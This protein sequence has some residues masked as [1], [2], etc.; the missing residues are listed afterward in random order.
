MREEIW[1]EKIFK[2]D[3]GYFL[4]ITK[5]PRCNWQNTD[6]RNKRSQQQIAAFSN[7]SHNDLRQSAYFLAWKRDAE[8]QKNIFAG[9]YTWGEFYI[10]WRN[11]Q[12]GALRNQKSTQPNF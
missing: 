4:R 12:K 11:L 2:D 9:N 6:E 10:D 5:E 8:R 1:T 7:D 3:A